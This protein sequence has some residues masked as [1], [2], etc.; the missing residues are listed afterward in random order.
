MQNQNYKEEDGSRALKLSYQHI[1]AV[2]DTSAL[3]AER[4]WM[5]KTSGFVLYGAD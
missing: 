1:S 3:F 4:R 5:N 2:S